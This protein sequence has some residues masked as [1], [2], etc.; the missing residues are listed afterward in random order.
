MSLGELRKKI[1]G[2]D[3]EIVRLLNERARTALEIGRLKK[4]AGAQVF[5]PARE[6]AV[7]ERVSGLTE[8]PL[9]P[10]AVRAIYREVISAARALERRAVIAYLGPPATFTHMAARGRFG[11]G[12]E[13]LPCETIRDVFAM[14][15]KR[16]ADHGVVPIENS[17]EGAVTHTL[18]QF[19]ETPL[20]ICAEIYLPISLHLVANVARE[21]I[22]KV[23]SKAEVFG[24]CRRWLQ[25]NLTGVDFV[26]VSST[27]RGAE[28]AA[29][30]ADAAAIAGRLAAELYGLAFVAEDIQDLGGNTTRFLVLARAYGPPSGRDRTSLL[31]AVKDKV[32]ALY[33][34]LSVFAE[35]GIN[36]TK[37]ESRPSRGKAWE[38]YFFVDVEGHADDANVRRALAEL[39]HH[40]SLL[41]VLGSY[42]L[43]E[44]RES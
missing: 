8:G 37:I 27:T 23:Y 39:E 41:T 30:E 3:E 43:A 29:K 5:D 35:S 12:V 7:F 16:A 40:C 42:P 17:T 11:A 24:Q 22:R 13:Y 31:F 19:I 4:D 18:D 2:L 6:R 36:M 14:V 32:G 33:H 34:T 1:D 21:K 20:R 44:G 28:L 26:P 15:E 38:Y 10:D 9:P 25:Q